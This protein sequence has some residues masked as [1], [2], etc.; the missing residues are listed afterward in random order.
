MIQVS[1]LR[2]SSVSKDKKKKKIGPNGEDSCFF[3]T[4]S[5]TIPL[6]L[7]LKNHRKGQ[8]FCGVHCFDVIII[9]SLQDLCAGRRQSPLNIKPDLR[10]FIFLS[11]FSFATKTQHNTHTV[12]PPNTGLFPILTSPFPFS[13]FGL[14]F[15]YRCPPPLHTPQCACALP[16]TLRPLTL[17]FFPFF[18]FFLVIHPILDQMKCPSQLIIHHAPPLPPPPHPQALFSTMRLNLTNFLT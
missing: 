8:V 15:P 14:W 1:Q 12:T 18:L 5:F 6:L 9:P 11:F 16:L 7:L 10:H 13:G 17:L 3:S 2:G 4:Y